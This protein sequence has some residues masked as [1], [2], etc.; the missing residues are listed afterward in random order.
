MTKSGARDLTLLAS[1]IIALNRLNSV[2]DKKRI[3]PGQSREELRADRS[4]EVSIHTPGGSSYLRDSLAIGLAARV[5]RGME[6]GPYEF[7]VVVKYSYERA[8]RRVRLRF[9]RFELRL[10]RA[11]G[12]ILC[13]VGSVGG[14]MRTSPIELVSLVC[15]LANEVLGGP[16]SVR[17]DEV[18]CSPR[19]GRP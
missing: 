1:L 17:S 11:G 8:G 5:A 14:V 13:R 3:I 19:R 15:K 12:G 7:S 18:E 10:D 2:R 4:F 9:D 6:V 16:G